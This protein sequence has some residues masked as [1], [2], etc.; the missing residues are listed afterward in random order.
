MP[1]KSNPEPKPVKGPPQELISRIEH[2][3]SLVN[4]LPLSLPEN[5]PNSTYRFYLDPD[6]LEDR[7]YLGELSHAL[8]VSFATHLRPVQFL[9][10]GSSL[11]ALPALLKTTVKQMSTAEREVFRKAWLERLI[12]AAV[13][14]GAKVPARGDKRKAVEAP[15][16]AEEPAPKKSKPPVIIVD[17]SDT[18]SDAPIVLPP[19]SPHPI[20]SASSTR[21]PPNPSPPTSRPRPIGNPKQTTL[22]FAPATKEDVQRYWKNVVDENAEKRQQAAEQDKHRAEKKKERER[23]QGRERQRRKRARDRENTPNDNVP[24]KRNVNKVLMNGAAAVADSSAI[25]DGWKKSRN[26]TQGG[27]RVF[28]YHPFLWDLISTA[29]IRSGWSAAQAL[30]AAPG[31]TLHR[32]TLW[33]WIEEGEKSRRTLIGSGRVGVLA[34]HPEVS[35]EIVTTL[36]GLRTAG[37]VVNKRNPAILNA[38]KC[39][40][41]FVRS[42]LE[43]VLDW[44]SRKATRAAKHIPDNAG[45]LT[46]RT[47]F[48]LVQ[49]IE[50]EHVPASLVVNYDQTGN[51]ILPNGSQTFEVRG[52]KQ[53]SVAGKDEKRA[54]TIGMATCAD[55]KPLPT[56]QIWSGKSKLSLPKETADGY[57]QVKDY[58]SNK[59]TSH[60]STQS[61][62]QDWVTKAVI[63]A[64]QDLDDDQKIILYI[65]IYPVHTSQEFR[66]FVFKLGN[67]ILIFPQDVGLQRVAK[68]KLK[69][70]M[71][72]YLIATGITPEKV[73][74]SSSYPVLRDASVRACS[75]DGQAVIKRSWEKCVVPGKPQYNLSYQCLTSRESRK[76]LREYLKKDPTLAN[77]IKDRCGA[78]HLDRLPLD[79]P[80]G[81]ADTL[82][83]SNIDNDDTHDDSDVPLSTVLHDALGDGLNSPSTVLPVSTAAYDTE[84]GVMSAT[85]DEED[86]WGYDDSGRKWA[87]LGALQDDEAAAGAA[88]EGSGASSDEV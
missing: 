17:D 81:P 29:V 22:Q 64:D 75:L 19:L 79:L 33:K 86:I 42:F 56:E 14:A 21:L 62:M 3:R 40:E 78:T 27:V 73:V 54:Y 43:S 25:G 74:F 88:G 13:A 58:A 28:W 39:S 83:E 53:V 37:C 47:F 26:G 84:S 45:E 71:L 10:R 72:E 8:E 15:V 82:P 32:A 76:A 6:A 68:H 7:G 67:I 66:D 49:A 35:E 41:K 69:Q 63:E 87:D 30:F 5:P 65:D 59:K 23:D 4:N 46:E 50:S 51:Y 38:F 55:G 80:N 11:N 36:R 9:Q 18:D 12:D 60:F 34:R 61:T 24:D 16:D 44:S 70:S 57:Q 20:P 48:R 31:S 52:A 85:N 77:E 1:P 2:L